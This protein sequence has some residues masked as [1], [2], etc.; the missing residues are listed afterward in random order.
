MAGQMLSTR[1]RLR[2]GNSMAVDQCSA[3]CIAQLCTPL[4]TR[5]S[6]G[7]QASSAIN[8]N[9]LERVGFFVPW[10]KFWKE[11]IKLA[12]PHPSRIVK[13]W[14]KPLQPNPSTSPMKSS[15]SVLK[16]DWAKRLTLTLKHLC[17]LNKLLADGRKLKSPFRVKD[18][19][20]DISK[21]AH[22]KGWALLTLASRPTRKG[23]LLLY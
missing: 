23:G 19:M 16:R 15:S 22:P 9:P 17:L 3:A 18:A 1:K 21:L 14:K 13:T 10:K 7:S 20:S 2:F 6:I 8:F 4:T 5:K 11:K 12:F